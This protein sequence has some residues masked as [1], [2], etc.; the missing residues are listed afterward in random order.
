METLAGL[1]PGLSVPTRGHCSR[2]S[3][4]WEKRGGGVGVA[5]LGQPANHLAVA[6]ADGPE[7]EAA[8]TASVGEQLQTSACREEEE[9]EQQLWR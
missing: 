5:N 6:A 2:Q 3:Q 1:E 9:E 4:R 7:Q 8:Q